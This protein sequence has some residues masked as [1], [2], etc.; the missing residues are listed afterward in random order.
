MTI[1][2]LVRALCR[3]HADDGGHLP[4]KAA[5]NTPLTTVYV[6][7]NGVKAVLR[8]NHEGDTIPSRPQASPGR[9]ARHP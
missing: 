6:E 9:P 5:G 7:Q 1:P 2:R 3:A 4:P 8:S